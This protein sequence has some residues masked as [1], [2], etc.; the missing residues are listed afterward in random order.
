MRILIADDHELFNELIT[1]VAL[2]HGLA[3]DVVSCRNFDD[4]YQIVGT[5]KVGEDRRFDLIILDMRMPGMKGCSGLRRMLAVAGTTPVAIISGMLS[6]AEAREVMR[7]GAAG[8]LPKTMPLDELKAAVKGLLVGERYVPSY[9]MVK[10][11]AEVVQARNTAAAPGELTSRERQVLDELMQG[12][13]NKEIAN[14][15]GITEITVKSHLMHLFRKIN[16]RNRT[17]AVRIGL[18]FSHEVAA[19]AAA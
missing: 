7:E 5:R 13:S 8:F 4:A 19:P 17:D 2:A 9:L 6:P 18:Q 3:S 12:W 1:N 16:A 10:K 14:N 11:D 15:L